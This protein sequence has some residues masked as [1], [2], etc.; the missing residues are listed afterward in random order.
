MITTAIKDGTAQVLF[1]NGTLAVVER[2]NPAY[3]GNASDIADLGRGG[4]EFFRGLI[5][6]VLVYSR[7]LSHEERKQIEDYLAEK[8]SVTIRHQAENAAISVDAGP[9][10]QAIVAEPVLLNG[11]VLSSAP[12]T[13]QVAWAKTR[14][15]GEVSFQSPTSAITTASFSAAGMYVLRLTGTDGEMLASDEVAV[16]VA[17]LRRPG[18]TPARDL[19]AWFRADE[20]LTVGRGTVC[21]WADQSGAERDAIQP[22][23]G[24]QPTFQVATANLMPQVR[25][26]GTDD[27]LT[28]P[29]LPAGSTGVTVVVAGAAR[30][31]ETPAAYGP[32]TRIIDTGEP[33]LAPDAL[34]PTLAGNAAGATWITSYTRNA[35]IESVS[36]KGQEKITRTGLP[37][38]IEAG[39]EALAIGRIGSAEYATAVVHE[40]LIYARALS[41]EERSQSEQYLAAKYAGATHINS[42]AGGD[43]DGVARSATLDAASASTGTGLV[44]GH[45]AGT[46]ISGGTASYWVGM[47]FTTGTAPLTVTALGR[48]MRSGDSS[49]HTLKLVAAATGTNITGGSALVS[50]SGG[51]PGQ[52]K[53]TTLA[54]PVTLTANTT[55]Y[56]MC[57]ETEGI[58]RFYDNNAVVQTTSAAS[59]TGAVHSPTGTSNWAVFPGAGR[60]YGPVDILYAAANTTPAPVSCPPATA[61]AFTACYYDNPDFTALKVTRTEPAIN[62]DW[63]AGSPDASIAPD[64]FSSTWDGTFSFSA[65]DYAFTVASDDGIRLYID[66]ALLINGWKDQAKTTYSAVKTLTA[67]SH[68][69]RVEYY[70]NG[71]SASAKLSWTSTSSSTGSSSDTTAPSVPSGLV[72]T[73]VSLSQINLSWNVCSDNIGIAGYRIFR[74]GVQIAAVAGTSYQNTALAASTTYTY[75]VAAYDAAGN[76]S[77]QSAPASAT[78]QGAQTT[79]GI[80]I[81]TYGARCDGVTNDSAAVQAALNAVPNG[82]TVDIPCMAAVGS[83]GIRLANK[84]GVTVRGTVA[85]SGFR[86]LARTG[87]NIP[88][89]GPFLFVIDTCN[90]CIIS[91]LEFQMNNVAA[92][93][94]GIT[95]SSD[96]VIQNNKVFNAGF[97]TGGAISASVNARNR[98]S[99]NLVDTTGGNGSDGSRGM[100]IGNWTL[101]DQYPI[102]EN[103]IVRR[104][105]GT[106]IASHPVGG[107]YRGNVAEDSPGGGGI[108]VVPKPGTS[109]PILIESNQLRRNKFLGLQI[110]LGDSMTI[111]NNTIESNYGQGIALYGGMASEPTQNIT[112]ES[113]IILNN[114][115]G[116][117][118]SWGMGG[119]LIH[120]GG[121]N[122]LIRNNSIED[123]MPDRAQQ[124]GIWLYNARGPVYNVRIEGNTCKNNVQHGVV[125]GGGSETIDGVAVSNNTCTSNSGYG[126]YLVKG[127]TS[128][129]RNVTACGNALTGNGKGPI[130][131]NTGL[132]IS[133]PLCVAP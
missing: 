6:E 97:F 109:A 45:T 64:T 90:S 63:S 39:P 103:N 3:I 76:T 53:Y 24:R 131:N 117:T 124:T 78:T 62:F 23:A 18:L 89:F 77:S 15:P 86:A 54:V 126:L 113:N 112:I 73:A 69:I 91:G 101:E 94:I 22:D 12:G 123:R 102:V 33:P 29:P 68:R 65:A 114:N 79:G 5:A 10:Q 7:A 70:E 58:D 55:Y 52:F 49:T 95:R 105:A 48:M 75:T 128:T 93:G 100:W 106:N 17:A 51:T 26:D 111:R 16:S 118:A 60:T 87:L 44:T 130:Y 107:T 72:A 88:A 8:Y 125:V 37:P 2:G 96:A 85:G 4:A 27:F 11:T 41:P 122:L 38:V 42:K 84:T 80:D 71:G 14:G 116:K 99:G 59:V 110:D 1:V 61:G 56:L 115:R 9:Q 30:T 129:Y 67:G 127:G 46:L 57:A 108:K 83:A 32:I 121:Q 43:V 120:D 40:I 50:M 81:R 34:S 20:G 36:V 98:Y 66:G 92:G 104:A 28:I 25:F 133:N 132:P 19:H 74:N 35:G 82:G 47:R 21:R 13:V 119:I 31:G